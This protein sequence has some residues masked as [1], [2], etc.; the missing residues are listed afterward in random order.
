[1]N[2]RLQLPIDDF[3]KQ[4]QEVFSKN[5]NIILTA[6]PG[7]GK[8]TRV[9]PW[10][11]GSVSGQVLVLEPRRLAAI[12]A[13]DR[14]AQENGWVLGE[15][16][17]Y[18]VR[19][20]SKISAK[21]RIVF[22]T[23]KLLTKKIL[24]DPELKNVSAVVFD[25]FHERSLDADLALGHL[26]E[27]Q[28]LG[29]EIKIVVMSATL[30]VEK[31]KLFF[32]EVPHIAVPGK[33]FPLSE[34]HSK[35]TQLLRL[36]DSFYRHMLESIQ[37]TLKLC[38]RSLL[39]FLP[40]AGEIERLAER[41]EAHSELKKFPIYKLHGSLKLEQ[42]KAVLTPNGERR[43]ILCTNIAESALTVDGVDGVV[44]SGLEK[45]FEYDLELGFGAL[46]LR[47]ISLFSAKQRG[48][49]S[50]RQFPGTVF[51][52][53]TH[54]D[55]RSMKV[56]TPS[57]LQREDLS[58][59]LLTLSFLGVSQWSQFTW[60]EHPGENRLLGYSQRLRAMGLIDEQNQLTTLGKS[61]IHWP[62]DV[63]SAL[64]LTQC[65]KNNV[66][67]LGIIASSLLQEK[68]F[69]SPDHVHPTED[70]DLLYRIESFLDQRGKRNHFR[71]QQLEKVCLQLSRHFSLNKDLFKQA[72]ESLHNENHREQFKNA[73][74]LSCLDQLCR[75][76]PQSLK[77]VRVDRK[78]MSLAS[79]SFAQ[80]SD[81]FAVLSAFHLPSQ[82]DL[83][84]DMASGFTIAQVRTALK[85]RLTKRQNLVIDESSR[86]IYL[87]ENDFFFDLEIGQGPRKLAGP[88]Q[89][90]E[91]LPAYVVTNWNKLE[92]Q[93]EELK[94]IMLRLKFLEVQLGQ[95]FLSSEL[96]QNIS[97][98]ICFGA[99]QLSDLYE[100]D[101]SYFI[102]QELSPE[103]QKLLAEIP[104]DI[105]VPS[106][107][108]IAINY[109]DPTSPMLSV[110]LQE[111]FGWLES[112]KLLNKIKLRIE[113]LGPNFRPVQVTSDL[114]SFW[115]NTYPEVRRELKIRYPKH[116]WPEDPKTAKAEAKGRKR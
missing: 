107:S 16:V 88:E 8:T 38:Q 77:G 80:N 58:E 110:R 29:H 19:F 75:R 4:I 55:E 72:S 49:R 13:A 102:T 105:L 56:E 21:S 86:K 93:I 90:Q 11:I 31:L 25:E 70:C 98:K 78:G 17:G 7:A 1:M 10:L 15:E 101:W 64:L 54:L 63:R 67:E 42:Q 43:L 27:L 32:G 34:K 59:I 81:Y 84:V 74:L 104:A 46:S 44:D 76:R 79:T 40:G 30:S 22:L 50:A 87:E 57:A 3:Q 103:N 99:Q 71:I 24:Q 37:E 6:E 68:D 73:V 23:E 48:G 9:P 106:G 92:K 109:E 94:S 12:A 108:R 33:L 113:L 45:S 114:S 97:E 111:L 35:A 36:D 69:L 60:F 53:W 26:R 115:E 116:S 100:K 51:K 91:L 5:Q 41:I 52:V 89:V 62:L 14:I 2:P 39:V 61:L 65:Q 82:V 66:T 96:K 95:N 112:P 85:D 28:M 83:Q 20:E 18:Q 47:R